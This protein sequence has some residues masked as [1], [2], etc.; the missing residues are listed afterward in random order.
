MKTKWRNQAEVVVYITEDKSK[1]DKVVCYTEWSSEIL[2][3]LKNN[4]YDRY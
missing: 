3:N 2:F 4:L 1:A